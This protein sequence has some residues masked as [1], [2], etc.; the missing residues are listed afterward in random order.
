MFLFMCIRSNITENP[1]SWYQHS[2]LLKTLNCGINIRIHALSFIENIT[3]MGH[4]K[5]KQNKAQ[6]VKQ[7]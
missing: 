4:K 7:P 2:K 1:K 5:Q 3:K 6:I